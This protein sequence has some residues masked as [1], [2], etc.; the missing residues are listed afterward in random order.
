LDVE[1]VVSS[2][3]QITISNTTG[4]STFSSSIETRIQTIDGG[5]Y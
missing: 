1:T 3:S 2:S 4:F 5:T